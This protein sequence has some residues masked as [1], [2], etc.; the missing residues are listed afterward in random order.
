MAPPG[1]KPKPAALHVVQGTFRGDRHNPNEPRPKPGRPSCPRWLMDEAKKEW[2][3]IAPELEALGM[4]TQLDRAS[5]ATYCQ[6]W[7]RFVEAE[8]QV[9][10]YG[11]VIA[12]KNSDYISV[13]PWE[14]LRRSNAA[15]VRA[16]ASE[17]GL[18]PSA[19]TRI[20]VTP[21]VKED[22]FAEFLTHKR[23][24]TR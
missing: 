6:A 23:G 24:G 22:E 19:R 9:E 12:A 1:R 4:L 11:S 14:T 17:F 20:T 5:L 10:R 16:F 21:P 2:K 7:A 3:R 8:E 18:T 15:T 13:S